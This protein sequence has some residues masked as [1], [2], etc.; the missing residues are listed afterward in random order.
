MFQIEES[1]AQCF[2]DAGKDTTACVINNYDTLT[3]GG[4]PTASGGSGNYTY[5]WTAYL[6]ISPTLKFYASDFLDDT[7]IANPRLI[8]P[9]FQGLS[10]YVTVIDSSGNTCSD[11][12]RVEFC[13]L[14]GGLIDIR[15]N[16]CPGDTI[17]LGTLGST[18]C[19]P[20]S[21]EWFPKYNISDPFSPRPQAWPDTTTYYYAIVTDSMGCQW[22][23]EVNEIFVCLSSLEMKGMDLPAN[24]FPNPFNEDILI[25]MEGHENELKT[26]TLLSE[27][28]KIVLK[29]VFKNS[30]FTIDTRNLPS[31]MYISVLEYASQIQRGKMFKQ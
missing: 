20:L 21:Y 17:T 22:S 3:L 29:K 26:F 4:S 9:Y 15:K 12:I 18:F 2:A 31:G 23:D 16:I 5:A 28:G 24:I 30:N 1:S 8:N 13:R 14:I 27:E 7:T 6:E 25:E 10:Y 11:S 19:Y